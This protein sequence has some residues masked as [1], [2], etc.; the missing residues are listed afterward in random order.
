[1]IYPVMKEKP[2]YL[3]SV[4]AMLK[5]HS[6][7][8]VRF[9]L[10]R[11]IGQEGANSTV[12]IATD[13]QLDAEVVVKTVPK[14]DLADEDEYFQEATSLYRSGHSNVVPVHYACQDADNIHLVIPY[15]PAGS[16]KS[17]MARRNLTVREI[18][19]LSTQFLSGL[20]NIHSKGLIHFDI[21]P[22]NIL[23]TDRG[24]AVISDF[25]LAKQRNFSG[26]AEQD[27]IYG[28]M[29]PPEGFTVNEFCHRFD[30]YQSGL[31]LYRMAM[32]DSRFYAEYS[33]F[34]SGGDLDSN[35]FRHAVLNGQFPS[36]NAYP[37]HIAQP[38]ID[39][40][41]T[42]LARVPLERFQSATEIVSALAGIDGKLLDWQ[43][44]LI[45]D[46]RKWSKQ[47][48][49][50]EIYLEVDAT[51]RSIAAKINNAGNQ[52]RIAAYC[53]DDISRRDIKKFLREH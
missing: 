9:A 5:P 21:K 19:T 7:A 4:L 28:K 27:R 18:V 34:L 40:I 11:E 43:Y 16:L 15:F 46:I 52:R 44:T 50:Q 42:C 1:M 41:A 31:T 6:I 48:D 39:C 30:V 32:G 23:L 37:E 45:G 12:R 33:S 20:H 2:C 17:L 24:E 51:G 35:R 53:K 22:D 13:L 47:L 8:E 29:I 38:I 26:V 25:G 10:G 3:R 49:S 14:L 36:K